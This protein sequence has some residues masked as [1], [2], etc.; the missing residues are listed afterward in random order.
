MTNEGTLD[1]GEQVI[2]SGKP[3]AQWLA[4]RRI[5]QPLFIAIMLL[6]IC[7][8]YLYDFSYAGPRLQPKH[9]DMVAVSLT[10]FGAISGIGS[11]IGFTAAVWLWLRTFRTAY[12]LTDRRVIIDVRGPFGRRTSIPLEH[13]RFIDLR[14]GFFGLGDLLFNETQRF[15]FDGWG[16]RGEGF[17][18][19]PDAARVERLVRDAIDKTFAT[20]SRSPW[21]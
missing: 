13:V 21:R 16:I 20:R 19:I 7:L 2:W 8:L 17:M 5:S 10:V 18:A 12:Y 14:S 15:S 3:V 1:A 11:L 9:L 4:L 6:T